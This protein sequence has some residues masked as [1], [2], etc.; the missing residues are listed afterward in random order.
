MPIPQDTTV[1]D[2][3]E[4]VTLLM[5]PEQPIAGRNVVFNVR[6]LPSW[7]KVDVTFTEPSGKRAGWIDENDQLTLLQEGGDVI[8][9]VNYANSAGTA[10]WTRYGIQD[11][12]GT[13]RVTLDFDGRKESIAYQLQELQIPGLES[14]SLGPPYEWPPRAGS[15]C[16]LLG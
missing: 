16:L 8:T 9:G 4:G 3:G 1:F 13:W 7:E 5:S 6:G 11:A 14:F 10:A 15:R 2:L 12:A